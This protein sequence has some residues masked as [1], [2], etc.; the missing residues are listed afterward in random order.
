MALRWSY[1]RPLVY[2]LVAVEA[3]N[4]LRPALQSQVPFLRI[5]AGVD[6]HGLASPD[7]LGNQTGS[8]FV[9]VLEPEAGK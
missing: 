1:D 3:E 6:R 8:S 5:G 7:L 9:V 2:D 4:G